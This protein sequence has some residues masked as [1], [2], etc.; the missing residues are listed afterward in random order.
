MMSPVTKS[1]LAF[2]LRFFAVVTPVVAVAV[3]WYAVTDPF[4]VLRSY[5]DYYPSP[6]DHPLRVGLNKGMVTFNNLER[7][8]ATGERYN[9]FIFGSSISCY[10]DTGEWRLLLRRAGATDSI[11]P[12]HLDSSNESLEAMA[13]KVDWLCRHDIPIRHALVVL[14]PVIMAQDG[15]NSPAYLDPP[16]LHA[17]V[18]ETAAYHYRFFRAATNADFLKSWIAGHAAGHAVNNG[19]NIIF[20]PQPIVYEA[21]YNQE[22]IPMWDAE[23]AANPGTFYTAH[24]LLT[25][26]DTIAESPVAISPAKARALGRIAEVFRKDSTDYQIIIGPNRRKVALNPADHATLDSIFH[27]RRVHDLSRSMAPLLEADSALYDNT[28]YRP[29]IARKL[30]EQVYGEMEL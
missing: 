10:Y 7:R 19:R 3:A 28:H 1:I 5:A 2:M 17:S 6:T 4:M 23:I 29:Y 18:F 8:L 26:G 12:Y 16:A 15:G 9:S 14:D 30:M 13:R 22:S 21:R 27:P 24:P 11:F 25:V 20:E